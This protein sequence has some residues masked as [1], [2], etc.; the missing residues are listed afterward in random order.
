MDIPITE[1]PKAAPLVWVKPPPGSPP[2]YEEHAMLGGRLLGHLDRGEHGG[3][4]FVFSNTFGSVEL[5]TKFADPI[6]HWSKEDARRAAQ[7]I[8]DAYVRFLVTGQTE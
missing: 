7:D 1:I 5:Y 4:A 8:L 2:S 3:Y 6:P